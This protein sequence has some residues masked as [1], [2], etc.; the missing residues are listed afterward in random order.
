LDGPS[1]KA[2]E[3]VRREWQK[4]EIN[5][6]A[7]EIETQGGGKRQESKKRYIV[8]Y[9]RRRMTRVTDRERNERK[10]RTMKHTAGPRQPRTDKKTGQ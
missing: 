8:Q 4:I 1:L 3:G 10:G 2:R 5:I 9:N 7:N 6:A